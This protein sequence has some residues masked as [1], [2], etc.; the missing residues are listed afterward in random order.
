MHVESTNT[1][2]PCLLA[3][4]YWQNR[5]FSK[6]WWEVFVVLLAFEVLRLAVPG[7][8]PGH[9]NV[10]TLCC[11]SE[12][13]NGREHSQCAVQCRIL[14]PAKLERVLIRCSFKKGF[15]V[16]WY[17]SPFCQWPSYS[18]SGTCK[19]ISPKDVT[20]QFRFPHFTGKAEE[21][22]KVPKLSFICSSGYLWSW[23]HLYWF[24][25]LIVN[26]I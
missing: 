13:K 21:V 23:I 3:S 17:S 6:C 2:A 14:Q 1:M 25:I 10:V 18:Y 20:F 8:W 26:E 12:C 5:T 22:W 15:M 4:T 11:P 24:F 9:W 19:S 7:R 16:Q